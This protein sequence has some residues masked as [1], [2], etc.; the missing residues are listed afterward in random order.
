MTETGD[1]V[2]EG[3]VPT[4]TDEIWLEEGQ[5]LIKKSSESLEGAAKAI[6]A[7][8]TSLIMIYTVLLS[9]FGSY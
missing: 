8:I 7:L 6:I 9:Y 4:R 5:N 2:S 3:Q 1:E